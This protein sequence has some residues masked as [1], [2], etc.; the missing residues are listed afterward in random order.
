MNLQ[1]IKDKEL[2][3]YTQDITFDDEIDFISKRNAFRNGFDAACKYFEKEKSNKTE[4]TPVNSILDILKFVEQQAVHINKEIEFYKEQ[5]K[6]T[7]ALVEY[8]KYLSTLIE[9]FNIKFLKLFCTPEFLRTKLKI[10][11]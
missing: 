3:K 2:E 4:H 6:D 7:T 1:E 5:Q 9:E 11:L 8:N 10:E